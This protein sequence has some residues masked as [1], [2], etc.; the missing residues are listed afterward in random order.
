MEEKI[1]LAELQKNLAAHKDKLVELL[2]IFDLTNLGYDMQRCKEKEVLNRVLRE[3]VFLAEKEFSRK[4]ASIKVGDRITDEEFDF[5]LSD[6]DTERLFALARPL[7]VS[8]KVTDENGRYLEDWIGQ[9][10][11]ARRELIDF[12]LDNVVPKALRKTFEIARQNIVWSD[13][14]IDITKKSFVKAA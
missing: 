6:E 10:C 1:L 11:D 12:L 5:L 2:K 14:L 4:P 8:E 9:R 13:R 7:M 3:N